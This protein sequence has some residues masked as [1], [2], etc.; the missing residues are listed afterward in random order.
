MKPV[1][2]LLAFLT[3]FAGTA[4]AC[5]IILQDTPEPPTQPASGTLLPATEPPAPSI[6]VTVEPTAQQ[7]TETPD[8][9]IGLVQREL[10]VV[11][12]G[13]DPGALD[14]VSGSRDLYSGDVLRIQEGGEGLLDFGSDMRLRLFNNTQM[15]VT[16]ASAPGTPFDV[17]LF[18]ED[19]G[20]TGELTAPGGQA[21]FRT[22][23][24]AQITVLGTRFLVAFDPDTGTTTVANFDG[25]VEVSAPE[26]GLVLPPAMF[27]LV[28]P[29]Q[30]PQLPRPFRVSMEEYNRVARLV[31]SP[32]LPLREFG[33]VDRPPL[34]ELVEVSTDFVDLGSE[35]SGT[36]R[37][38]WFVVLADD[39]AGPDNLQ[40][41]SFWTLEG[42]RGR[43]EL[44]RVDDLHYRGEI[45]DFQQPGD[46]FIHVSAQDAAGQ[47]AELDPIPVRVGFCI[48]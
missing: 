15:G 9:R 26:G 2:F 38:V 46:L 36:A 7:P 23:N 35:C 47:G 25:S 14:Q 20:F 42:Q 22:P 40:V 30:A 27:T 6:T 33:M 4:L 45:G 29:G 11:Q 31:Q 28:M 39:D 12:M 48:G 21:V 19:G 43:I 8:D 24:N 16:A 10:D 32:L 1:K 18:L 13:K 44:E 37:S 17:R 41:E 34:L 3:L 5:T